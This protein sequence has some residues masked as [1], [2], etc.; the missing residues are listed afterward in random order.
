MFRVLSC[1]TTEHDW[2]L[3]VVAGAV[4]FLASLTAIHLFNRARANEFRRRIGWLVAAGLVTGSGIW[5]T[6]FIAMLAYEPGMTIAYNVGLTVVSLLIAALVTGLGLSLALY[7]SA[8]WAAPAS[9]AVVGGGVACMHYLGMSAVEL[10]G[11]ITWSADLVAASILAGMLLGGAALTAA[12]NMKRRGGVF[13]AGVLLTLAIVS[14]H[15]TA[16]GAVE[17]LPDPAREITMLS[18]SPGVLAFIVASAAMTI[19]IVGLVSAVADGRLGEKS[20]LFETALNNM[21]QGVVM[22]DRHERLLVCNARYIEMYGLS[23]QIVKPGA[24]LSDVIRHRVRSG[25]LSGDSE[26]IRAEVIADFKRGKTY[27]RNLEGPNGQVISVS[28]R[29]VADGRYWIGTHDDITER[30]KAEQQ[31]AA[32]AEQGARRVVVDGAIA[33]FRQSVEGLLS[34]MR[35]SAMTMRTTAAGL[36]ET[37]LETSRRAA[38]AVKSSNSASVNVRAAAGMAEELLQSI[39]ELSRQLSHAMQLTRTASAEAQATNAKIAGLATAAQEIGV[40]VKLIGDIAGQTNLLALNATIE[41]ARAGEA[42][43]GFAVVASEVKSLAVQTA[44]ATEQIAAQIAAVQASAGFAVEAIQRNTAR[45]EEINDYTSTVAMAL[46]EQNAAT[47]QISQNVTDAAEST[48]LIVS[49]LDE[50]AGA[51]AASG[52]SAETVL[53][54]SSSVES[55]AADLREEVEMFLNKV[56]L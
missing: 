20:I 24:L 21:S 41:A 53:Q 25:S 38:G 34:G 52:M 1:L 2:R 8:R 13:C 56:A 31:S 15:F 29:A 51:V 4:C 28:N 43:R 23:P 42:G 19:L 40:V 11:R 46:E 47:S 6:H 33:S 30:L 54:A 14:H 45:M 10:P 32:L 35:E 48:A 3:V 12:V 9:G 17:V 37:S 27:A 36:S 5:A 18:V 55:A 39:D 16:M 44:K 7:S 22:Y 49:T 26:Q 50:V